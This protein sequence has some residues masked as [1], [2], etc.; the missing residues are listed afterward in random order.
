MK[1][2]LYKTTWSNPHPGKTIS[3][4]DFRSTMTDSSPFLIAISTE[5]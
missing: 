1:L 5:P 4:L 2:R 3:A